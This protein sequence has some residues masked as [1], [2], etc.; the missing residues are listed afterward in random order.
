MFKANASNLA[1]EGP[2][3]PTCMLNLI[4]A[5]VVYRVSMRARENRLVPEKVTPILL[6]R[7]GKVTN[8]SFQTGCVGDL[9]VIF[10]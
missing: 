9:I 7:K 1:K 4:T 8:L 2:R 6:R 10:A 3:A 5:W